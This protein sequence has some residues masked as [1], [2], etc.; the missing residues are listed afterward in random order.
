MRPSPPREQLTLIRIFEEL[1]GRGYKGGYDAVRKRTMKMS[2]CAALRAAVL[3]LG[4]VPSNRNCRLLA[5]CDIARSRMDF[6]FGGNTGHAADVT[7]TT[8]VD[9]I[10]D[11]ARTEMPQRSS[12]LP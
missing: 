2:S 9:P 4:G 10:C 7:A 1:R 11:I 6:R 5:L 12:L 8:D 3:I